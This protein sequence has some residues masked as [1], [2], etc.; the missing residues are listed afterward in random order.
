MK[1]H[2]IRQQRTRQHHAGFSLVELMI[3]MVLG[4]FI[5]GAILGLFVASKRTYNDTERL[6]QLTESG[7]YG[8]AVLSDELRSAD[9]WGNAIQSADVRLASNLDVIATDCSGDAAGYTLTSPITAVA[10]TAGTVFD[11]ITD[12]NLNSDVLITKHAAS[13]TTV[14]ASL[15]ANKTYLLSNAIVGVLFDGADTTPS[16]A[17]GGDVPNGQAW[18]YL[19]TAFYVGNNGSTPTLFRKQLTGNTWSAAQEVA[20]GVETLHVEFGED[21]NSDGTADRYLDAA[22]A[23][24]QHVVTAKIYLLVRTDEQDKAYV[25]GRTYTLGSQTITPASSDHYHRSVYQTTVNLRNR[26]LHIAGDQPVGG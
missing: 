14:L 15:D 8:L 4:M 3:G 1:A 20:T 17:N 13:T 12:A 10:A 9:F 23:N 16:V 25:D 26:Y 21:T 22:S 19:A 5:V 18:E 24:W 11:C 6:A 2:V 7:R